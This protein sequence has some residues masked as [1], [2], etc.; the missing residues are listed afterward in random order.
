MK[1]FDELYST[2]L[3]TYLHQ[4]SPETALPSETYDPHHLD[5][6]L[7]PDAYP[8]VWRTEDCSCKDR[9]ACEEVCGFGALSRDRDGNLVISG[10]E[11][12]GCED[13]VRACIGKVL[14]GRRDIA[15]VLSLLRE[16]QIPVYAM[17]APAFISQFSQAVTPGKLRA[18]FKKLGFAGMI[19]VSLFADIL[20]L[21]E[22]VE[23]DRN[24]LKDEDF[25]LTSCCC[26][27]WIAMIKKHYSQMIPHIPPSVSPMVA[28]GRSIKKLVPGASTVFIGPC[29]AKKAEA[30]EP[31]ISDAV[32]F[33]LTFQEIGDIFDAAGVIPAECE[34]DQRDHSSTAGRMYAIT[35]GV[36][37]AVK[38]TLDS[39]NP[40]RNIPLRAEQANGAFECRKMLDRI[41]NGNI[42]ANFLE[43]MGCVG[44]CV[45]GPRVLINKE[46]GTAFVQKYGRE[47]AYETP[48]NNPYVLEL[49][50]RLGFDT[51]GSLIQGN[52]MLTRLFD[53]K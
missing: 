50:H 15:P 23:F 44:G 21:K 16:N 24:I 46:A 4:K 6:L 2:V 1:S 40:G 26:P 8:P 30:K 20:T 22:A 5:C 32:D 52:N 33:V 17:I 18:A 35:G 45:G 34:D 38:K 49:L 39:I 29:L 14:T 13:C 53:K 28:C 7:H 27:V 41:M 42:T 11:C 43:G 51:I 37:Q 3:K 12:V 25:L 36:S 9:C 48:V 47:A 31:D 10:K 19:E